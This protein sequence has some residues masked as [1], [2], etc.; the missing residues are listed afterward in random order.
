MPINDSYV[1][2]SPQFVPTSTDDLLVT[3]TGG[4]QGRLADKLAAGGGGITQLTGDV[5]AGPG[6]GS[7]AATLATVNADVGSFTSANITVDAKGRVTAATDGGGGGTV[8]STG[9]IS[10]SSAQLLTAFSNPVL[11]IAAPGA[12]KQIKVLQV[13]YKYIFNA[14]PYTTTDNI[15]TFIGPVSNDN[16]ADPGTQIFNQS[17]NFNAWSV[18]EA[19]STIQADLE[20]Q[21]LFLGCPTTDPT[22]GDGTMLVNVLYWI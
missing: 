8:V 7:K 4:T 19:G 9:D 15:S 2:A 17:E 14:T 3:P 20:D 12:G 13:A 5:T 1:L 10:I 11:L 18:G 6:T 16:P 22:G 21:P